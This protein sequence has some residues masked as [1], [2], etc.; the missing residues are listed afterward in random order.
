MKKQPK[1]LNEE[2][3]KQGKPRQRAPGAGRPVAGRT[4]TL[5]RVTEESHRQFL[6]IA[7]ILDCSL[8]EAIE[9]AARN[10][11][12]KIKKTPAVLK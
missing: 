1:P 7:N 4:K 11:H 12:A 3:T 10:Y 6:D 9:H 5:P 2:L 8:A